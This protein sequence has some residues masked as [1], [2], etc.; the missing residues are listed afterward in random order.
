MVEQRRWA[1]SDYLPLNSK[2]EGPAVADGS[3][4]REV[5]HASEAETGV[6]NDLEGT[7]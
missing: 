2:F 4:G 6:A 1:S 3:A 7:I 5:A